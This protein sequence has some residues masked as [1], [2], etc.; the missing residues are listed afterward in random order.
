[1]WFDQYAQRTGQRIDPNVGT[2]TFR[3][4]NHNLY[5]DIPVP[6]T[7]DRYVVEDAEFL[8]Q[9]EPDFILV[10]QHTSSRYGTRVSRLDMKRVKR[11]GPHRIVF[12]WSEKEVRLYFGVDGG[13][14]PPI[15]GDYQKLA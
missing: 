1:M 6:I 10:F 14:D 12:V 9:R 15:Q 5:T 2:I 8:L 4:S 13:R 11:Q 3:I 7:I